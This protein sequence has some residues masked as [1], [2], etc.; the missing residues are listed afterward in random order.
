MKK[1]VMAENRRSYAWPEAGVPRLPRP[2]L[3]QQ[4]QL[5]LLFLLLLLLLPSHVY[6]FLPPLP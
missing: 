2:L 6:T 3:P 4:V 1:I 5:L